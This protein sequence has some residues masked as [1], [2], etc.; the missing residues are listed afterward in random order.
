MAQRLE[1]ARIRCADERGLVPCLRNRVLGFPYPRVG[2]SLKRVGE[3]NPR[4][5]IELVEWQPLF[6]PNAA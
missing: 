6:D 5:L 3:A 1:L 2:A 4:L